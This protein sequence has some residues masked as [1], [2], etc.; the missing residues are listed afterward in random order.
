[1]APLQG[2]AGCSQGPHA[3]GR[4][5]AAKAPMQRGGRLRQGPLQRGGRLRPGPARKGAAPARGQTAGAAARG[6]P[7][8]ARCPQGAT[9]YGF[10]AR[11]KAA[12]GQRHRPQGLPPARAAACKGGRQQGR[13]PWRCR[14][15]GW[16]PLGRVA[17]DGQGQSPPAQ[18]Q[19]RRRRHSEGE[20]GLRQLF[21]QR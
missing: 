6:W 3:K 16:P 2:A 18:V 8:A 9:D 17:A 10:D 12:R 15:Q 19:Q 4:P 5:A 7:A 21:I 1:M 14:P 20:G 13:R 11:R